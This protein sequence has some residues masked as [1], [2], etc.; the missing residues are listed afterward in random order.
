MIP[1][2]KNNLF[3]VLFID[4]L[5]LPH[6]AGRS[7]RSIKGAAIPGALFITLNFGLHRFKRALSIQNVTSPAKKKFSDRHSIK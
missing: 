1:P 3:Q 6:H 7:S 5:Y 4:S 2:F